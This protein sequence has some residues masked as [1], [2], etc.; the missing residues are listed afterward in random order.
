MPNYTKS[1]HEA[2]TPNQPS[3]SPTPIAIITLDPIDQPIIGAE[4]NI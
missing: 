4:M 2:R 1:D 3:A